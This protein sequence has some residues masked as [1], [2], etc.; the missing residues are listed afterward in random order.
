MSKIKID[1][2]PSGD[3]SRTYGTHAERKMQLLEIQYCKLLVASILFLPIFYRHTFQAITKT[4]IL[5]VLVGEFD[6]TSLSNKSYCVLK[7]ANSFCHSK[8]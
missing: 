4:S 1:N 5:N 8:I 2:K 3:K 7:I 6:E